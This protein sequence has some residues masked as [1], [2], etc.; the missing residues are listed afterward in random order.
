MEKVVQEINLYDLLKH[1]TKYWALILIFTIIGLASGVVYNKYV[2]VPTYKSDATLILVSNNQTST[3]TDPT[4]INNYIDLLKSHRVLDPVISSLKLNTTYD[5]LSNSVS[6]S[7][8]KTTE[9][10]KLSI[11]TKN[12]QESK[13]A[14]N[15][16][17]VSFKS[18]VARL[19]G[20]DNIE[21]V[22]S[23]NTPLSPNNV[24]KTLQLILFTSAG[25]LV[26]VIIV[27]F[28]YDF[29]LSKDSTIKTKG[30]LKNTKNNKSASDNNNRFSKTDRSP[31]KKQLSAN[32]RK[33]K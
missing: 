20:N 26:S 19:Y 29:R 28:I 6:A 23:A 4:V 30:P 14:V 27:F 7:N 13:E 1:Y 18:E 9:V 25:F 33:K 3:A 2:Q 5:Q 32:V 22:D 11:S 12:S 10:I 21:I 16:T 31:T 17:I 24:H 8:D 15:A